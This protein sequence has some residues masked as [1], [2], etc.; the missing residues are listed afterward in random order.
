MSPEQF[1]G[2]RVDARSDLFTFG[3]LL[4]EMLSGEPPFRDEDDG[5]SLLRRM[6]AGRYRSL[7]KMAPETPRALARLVRRCLRPKARKRMPS[8]MELRRTLEYQLRAPSP[9]DCRAE[10]AAWLWERKVFVSEQDDATRAQSFPAKPRRLRPLLP[11][12]AAAAASA[13]LLAAAATTS[14]V[15]ISSIPY[16]SSLFELAARP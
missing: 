1:L 10:I 11:W 4:Y 5:P 9:A 12:L 8:A 7:R 3:I 16:L 14:W 15:N 13:I 6:E 2:E